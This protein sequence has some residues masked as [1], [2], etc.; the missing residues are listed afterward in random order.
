MWLKEVTSAVPT[1]TANTSPMPFAGRRGKFTSS[2]LSNSNS[3][4]PLAV[5]YQKA[6]KDSMNS[7]HKL[8]QVITTY[9]SAVRIIE[10][11]W[12]VQ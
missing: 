12:S 7:T 6:A 11:T 9:Q 8:P 2:S 3:T 4:A 1:V 5:N 10:H